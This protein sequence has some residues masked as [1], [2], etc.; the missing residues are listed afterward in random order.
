MCGSAGRP[1][2]GQDSRGRKQYIYHPR[3]REV[4]DRTKYHR[5]GRFGRALARKRP[6]VSRA[7]S[8]VLLQVEERPVAC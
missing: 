6:Q 8:G 4:R 3:W 1:A 2:T 5:M 7:E